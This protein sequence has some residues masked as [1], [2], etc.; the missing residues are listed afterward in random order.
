M[1]AADRISADLERVLWAWSLLLIVGMLSLAVGVVVLAKPHI[2]LA[3]LA[4]VTGIFLL[5]DG[6][7]ELASA[8]VRRGESRALPAVVGIVSAVGGVILIRHPTK[9]V[10]VI[11]LLLGL[12]LII[13]GLI[14]VV[15]AV[16]QPAHRGWS[17]LSGTVELLGGI[18][19][20]SSPHI[21]VATLALLVGIAFVVRGLV[22]CAVAWALHRATSDLTAATRGPAAVS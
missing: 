18:V 17:I 20:V 9:A 19:V 14:R 11:A 10:A 1:K 6:V 8:L 5:A 22:L 21:G 15:R 2:S 7:L 13:L 16:D 12:W 3:T 4:V